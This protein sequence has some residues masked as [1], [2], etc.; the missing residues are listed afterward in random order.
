MCVLH[1]A[2]GTV[3]EVPRPEPAPAAAAATAGDGG[4]CRG[5]AA[6]C[7]VGQPVIVASSHGEYSTVV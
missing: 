3:T 6:E 1:I 2:S 4:R 7:I 5:E